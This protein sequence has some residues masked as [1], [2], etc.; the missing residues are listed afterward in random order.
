MKF[1]IDE[2]MWKANRAILVGLVRDNLELCAC[3]DA[4]M[5]LISELLPHVT[6][7]GQVM[8]ERYT[9]ERNRVRLEQLTKLEDDYPE[10]AAEIGNMP[11]LR[12]DQLL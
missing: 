7:G 3:Q 2:S 12:D 5:K 4:M 10:L 11:P 9:V 6:E 8:L 1:Q